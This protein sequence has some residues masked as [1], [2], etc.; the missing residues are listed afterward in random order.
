MIELWPSVRSS[1]WLASSKR[2]N[3][4]ST[5]DYIDKLV[6]HRMGLFSFLHKNR[7]KT[8]SGD[9]EFYSRAED[10]SSSSRPRSRRKVSKDAAPVDPVLPE[11]KRARRR[12]IGAVALVLA[13]IIGLPMLLD[14]E[15]KPLADD[16][17][18]DIPAKDR[19]FQNGVGHPPATISAGIAPSASLDRNEQLMAMP[20]K[21]DVPVAS[22]AASAAVAAAAT[23][24]DKAA[25]Q[26]AGLPSAVTVKPS[27]GALAKPSP[28]P[29]A[30]PESKAE[31]KPEAAMAS[32]KLAAEKKP[33]KFVIQIAAL[34][35][36][37]KVSELQ[38]KL[39]SAGVHSYTQKVA[40]Q[41]G[42]R[43]RIR[44]GPFGNRDEADRMR[45]KLI[46]LGLNGTLVPL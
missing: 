43:I 14:S 33:A 29:E 9:S 11:K 38:G 20:V 1:Q 25:D 5:A 41:G 10:E 12:L 45:T 44:V 28:K 26:G 23:P 27:P 22:Q 13:A 21:P 7:Q 34:A 4:E 2:G 37:E 32:A 31:V 15:P 18:I 30:K 42:D 19:A 6:K 24:D 17:A 40:T 46:K 39:K 3:P 16:I 8:A 35:T 36:Q